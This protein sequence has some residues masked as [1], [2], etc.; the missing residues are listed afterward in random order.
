[1]LAHA[2]DELTAPLITDNDRPYVTFSTVTEEDHRASREQGKV[3]LRDVHYAHVTGKG[4]KDTTKHKLPGWWD[5]LGPQV[6]SGRLK[7]EWVELWKRGFE[8]YLEG[9][10]VPAEGTP[11]L[12]W[13]LIPGSMQETIIRANIRTVEDLATAPA[14]ALSRIGM[15]AVELKRRAE[16]WV[17][18]HK[19]KEGL[20][21]KMAAVQQENDGLKDQLATLMKKVEELSKQVEK[22]G[23]G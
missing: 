6:A 9:K 17:A 2:M 1:M 8:K 18:Q 3:V 7:P 4:G 13:G 12:G 23:K 22:K 15:G 11:I 14:D 10:E 16:A 20:A 5:L 21:V 19:D